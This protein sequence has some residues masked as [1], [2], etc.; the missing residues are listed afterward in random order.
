M[1]SY[2]K[3]PKVVSAIQVVY[4][5]CDELVELG[6]QD[7]SHILPKVD[8]DGIVSYVTVLSGKTYVVANSTDWI[9]KENENYFVLSDES[10][11]NT[12]E[13]AS[14]EESTEEM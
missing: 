11:V 4:K 12:Y 6:K 13:L 14:V 3:I 2:I 1:L 7:P 5:N 8:S 9:I 10:F